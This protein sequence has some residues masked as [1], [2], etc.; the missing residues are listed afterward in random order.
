[1]K[2]YVFSI[3]YI[4]PCPVEPRFIFFFKKNTV[5]PDQMA[6]SEAI[7]SGI[8]LFS[9]LIENDYNCKLLQVNNIKIGE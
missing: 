2:E 4:I 9:T 7:W 6:S 3:D 8:T 1:M 5:D